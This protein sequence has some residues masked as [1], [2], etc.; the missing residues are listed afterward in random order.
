[1]RPRLWLGLVVV[2]PW[3]AS[4]QSIIP[5]PRWGHSA[6]LLGGNLY[7]VGGR[8]GTNG[9][10]SP[11]ASDN[12]VISV[13]VSQPFSTNS[14]P[15]TLV[16]TLGDKPDPLM[17][18][19]LEADA[20][21]KRLVLYGGSLGD[22]KS[23][24][25]PVW[26]LRPLEHTWS[27]ASSDDG[28]KPRRINAA[29]ASVGT[30]IYAYGGVSVSDSGQ[31]ERFNDLYRLSKD[32]LK[33]SSRKSATG[34]AGAL[35]QH[36]LSYVPGRNI[37]V[38]I[39]GAD[40]TDFASMSK[41]NWYDP[42]KDTWGT[43]TARGDIPLPRRE[44]SAVVVGERI[45]IFGGCSFNYDTFYNDV[46]VLDTTTFTWSKPTVKNAPEGRYEHS[47]TMVGDY[48]VVAFGFLVGNKGD[49]NI[50]A[51]NTK[52]W[53]FETSFP[54]VAAS[55]TSPG[56]QSDSSSSDG[57]S[58][59][60]ITG[61]VLGCAV[62]LALIAAAVLFYVRRRRGERSRQLGSLQEREN[63]ISPG[64]KQPGTHSSGLAAG[65]YVAGAHT[66]SSDAPG[67]YQNPVSSTAGGV[68]PYF[69]P[70]TLASASHQR[71]VSPFAQPSNRFSVVSDTSISPSHVAP[72]F[73]RPLSPPV[74]PTAQP[75]DTDPSGQL[76]QR[77]NRDS[78][79]STDASTVGAGYSSSRLA[80]LPSS[81]TFA[82]SSSF[83][84][85]E[86]HLAIYQAT[87]PYANDEAYEARSQTPTPHSNAFAAAVAPKQELRIANP[88]P[89]GKP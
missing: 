14:P 56:S 69:S 20:S 66:Y 46:A 10:T 32:S 19:I 9:L 25:N 50:Y 54:G 6:A 33:W 43:S 71:P 37:L 31:P 88:D 30:Y 3:M 80:P 59:G 65:S 39:G 72:G 49:T 13:D 67:V 83:V 62:A 41:I 7:I 68:A 27:I 52:T 48:M 44:H 26:T 35:F 82:A 16:D 11:M 4:G 18:G 86:E 47:A 61:I 87:Q 89:D 75:I 81:L 53:A 55:S 12:F 73:L 85:P 78:W 5:A 8:S 79:V 21:R 42:E 60:E 23:Q 15:W 22:K 51:L 29:S 17:D 58:S 34:N 28:P 63:A 76:D 64:A 40:A 36:T 74:P 1:M 45:I 57:L 70:I 24:S 38:S 77:T 2:A 84:I